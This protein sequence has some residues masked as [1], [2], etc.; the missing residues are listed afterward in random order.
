TVD[1]HFDR[2][3][4]LLVQRYFVAQFANF[5]V[6]A[7]AREAFFGGFFEQFGVLAL[8]AAHERREQRKARA[9]GQFEN[10][11]DDLLGGL[12]A[13]LAAAGRTVRRSDSREQQP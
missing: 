11:I 5:T 2:V 13:D 9:F 12:G 10:R 4:A 1:Y 6:N 3:L 7:N 8:A